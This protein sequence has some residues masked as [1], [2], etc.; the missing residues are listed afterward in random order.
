MISDSANVVCLLGFGPFLH[1]SSA[2]RKSEAVTSI[3]S[4]PLENNHRPNRG[5]ANDSRAGIVSTRTV[6]AEQQ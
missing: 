2:K 3:T 6:T 1:T 5:H 4:L